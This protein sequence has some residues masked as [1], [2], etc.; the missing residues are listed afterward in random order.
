MATTTTT[1]PA[2]A[3]T[4][5]RRRMSAA[6]KRDL[7]DGLL[8]TSPF[9]LGVLFLWAGPMLYSLFLI[10]QE[11]NMLKPPE[12]IGL[13]NFERMVN[14]P[15]VSKSF[16]NTVYYT[17]FSVPL[18]LLIAF[19]LALMLNQKI[20][21]IGF[22]RATFY[23]PAI[24]PAVAFAIVWVQ[25]LNPEFGV[26]NEI[27]SWVG[28]GP[29]KWLFD[30]VYAKPG[31]IIMSLWLVGPQMIIFLA[32]L[33]GVPKELMEA[34]EIDGANTWQRF[35]NVTWPFVSP[36]TF[37]NTV[38]GIIGSFQVFT[39]VYIMTR[40]SGSPQ[41]STLFYVLYLYQNGFDFFKMGYAA[42]LAWVLFLIILVFTA[43]QFYFANRWVYYEGST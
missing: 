34:A 39:S 41:Q 29:I 5:Q 25:I 24:T 15:L 4:S 32:G 16:W 1:P 28:I 12:F 35:K 37:F 2:T 23:V 30:P 17:V 43:I 3:T 10:T 14:D 27:L 22:Y 19:V 21:G 42:S 18:Q 38:I 13:G 9:I 20:R 26:L 36:I 7:R 31:L 6:A 11:W 8:F 33:Q 40:G